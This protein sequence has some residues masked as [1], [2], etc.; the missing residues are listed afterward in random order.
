M[1]PVES[2]MSLQMITIRQSVTTCVVCFVCFVFIACSVNRNR[3]EEIANAKLKVYCAQ[4]RLSPASFKMTQMD[5]LRNGW[6]IVF[7]GS[8]TPTHSFSVTIRG[9]RVEVARMVGG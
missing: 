6:F 8:T 1:R 9:S 4:E 7:D 2:I 3:A 5:H